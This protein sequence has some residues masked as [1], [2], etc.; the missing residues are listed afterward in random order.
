MEDKR[1][2]LAVLLCM[3]VLMFWMEIVMAPYNQKQQSPVQNVPNSQTSN[4]TVANQA[5]SQ[6]QANNNPNVVPAKK[7]NDAPTPASIK[8]AGFVNIE[9]PLYKI[10]ISKLGARLSSFQLEKYKAFL[11][12][13]NNLDLVLSNE[14]LLPL[15]VYA[16]ELNDAHTHY[17]VEKVEGDALFE[18]D[19]YLLPAGKNLVITLSG[20]LSDNIKI[21]KIITLTGGSY[22][23]KVNVKLSN[24]V[25]DGS[26][27]WLEWT[28]F[29]P[30]FEENSKI[31]LEYIAILGADNKV[32]LHELTSVNM[33][34]IEGGPSQ[35]ITYGDKY[36]MAS[37]ISS[38]AGALSR[39]GRNEFTFY[40]KISGT[41]Q[42]ADFHLYAGPKDTG[43]LKESGYQLERNVDLGMFAF[44]AHPLLACLSFFYKILGNYGLA[45]IL[46]TL[47]IKCLFLPLTKSSFKSMNA[48]Q[49]LQP[50]I[51]ALRERIQDPTQLNQEMM[52]LYKKH[53]V[54]PMGGCFP[55]LIQLPVFL[56][57]YNSL[58]N[59][60]ELR[61]A[62]FALWINDLSSVERLDV[63]GIGIP[64][65]VLLM[66][67][68]M[69]IQQWT[70]PSSA[71]PQ[72]KKIM[73]MMPVIFTIS[74]IIFPFPSGLVL[75]WLVNNLISI[76]QQVYLR[77]DKHAS[78]FQGTILASIAIF[79]VGFVLTLI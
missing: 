77:S 26:A 14:G 63:F 12:S 25:P 28:H 73:M 31:N 69:F 15:G 64:V 16:G 30:K 40:T 35:W 23:L 2:A 24:P 10:Q 37:L 19:T 79:F 60:I 76:I 44:I 38:Q 49:K 68:S 7:I 67:A 1:T 4:K 71:D 13:E 18:K 74:F 41:S 66:G 43:I 11:G 5:V 50:E 75:Y 70:T 8:E 32:K 36:F 42:N 27:V 59:A 56:G 6:I 29:N 17:S 51:K 61:H 46:L 45:I 72:Q 78:A 62:P 22:L 47:V 57:L 58:N 53:G 34:L 65:M 20:Q 54:N 52:G 33:L 9:S 55:M 48:M 21:S 39:M 3:F